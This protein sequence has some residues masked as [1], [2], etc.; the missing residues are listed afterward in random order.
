MSLTYFD[1]PVSFRCPIQLVLVAIDCAEEALSH[2]SAWP[3][4]EGDHAMYRAYS[5]LKCK[6]AVRDGLAGCFARLAFAEAAAAAGYLH[7]D[8]QQEKQ[9][10]DCSL[11]AI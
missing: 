11:I 10:A 5:V 4:V 6:A 9:S 2:M 7:I 1:E 3:E 8:E